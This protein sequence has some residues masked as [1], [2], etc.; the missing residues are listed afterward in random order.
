MTTAFHRDVN[1]T[2]GPEFH[3]VNFPPTGCFP[4]YRERVRLEFI[5]EAEKLLNSTNAA[6]GVSSGTGLAQTCVLRPIFGRLTSALHTRQIQAVCSATGSSQT[7][8]YPARAPVI[9]MFNS[10]GSKNLRII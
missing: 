3:E 7:S 8:R 9:N 2:G 5:G 1:S 10:L 6:F 4:I